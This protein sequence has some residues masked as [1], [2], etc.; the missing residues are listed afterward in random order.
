MDMDSTKKQEIH[1]ET[2]IKTGKFEEELEEDDDPPTLSPYALEA[3]QQFIASQSI[4]K[5]QEEKE[6]DE[7]DEDAMPLLPE[8]WRMSQFWYSP[9]TAITVSSEVSS[10]L[11][12]FTCDGSDVAPPSVACISCPTLFIYLKVI[13][14]NL[15]PLS[16]YYYSL[17]SGLFFLLRIL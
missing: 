6:A 13:Q 15:P 10:L 9:Q 2:E 1:P 16:S 7:N 3:L 14:F 4:S 8:D 17:I 12:Q 5:T 11:S